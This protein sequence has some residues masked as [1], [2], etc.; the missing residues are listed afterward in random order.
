MPIHDLGYRGWALSKTRESMRWRVMAEVG[1]RQAWGIMGVRRSVLVA[2]SPV[3]IALGLLFAFEQAMSEPALRQGLFRTIQQWPQSQVAAVELMKGE[4]GARHVLWSY[5]LL[6]FFRYPQGFAMLILVGI[7]GPPLISRDVRSRAFLLYFSRPISRVQYLIGKAAILVFYLSII[8]VVPAMIIFLVGLM[9][10]PTFSVI[11]A[12]WDLPFRIVLASL[13]L[14]VPATSL[15]LCLS[16]L[17]TESRNASFAWYV[18]WVLGFVAYASLANADAARFGQE[19]FLTYVS[20]WTLASPYHM[21]GR[22]QSFVFGIE[23]IDGPYV[24][25]SMVM[26]SLITG[27]CL[28]VLFR[29]V[30]APMRV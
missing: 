6:M 7:I 28:L 20:K 8:T 23:G 14:I 2:L 16:S 25:A 1:V 22:V 17:T 4:N 5:I 3:L 10:S 21:M 12:T 19:E 24:V 11:L 13:V 30:S 27:L 15:M 26:L 29:R 9:L 18:V